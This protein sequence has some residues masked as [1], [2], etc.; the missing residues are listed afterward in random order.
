MCPKTNDGNNRL[1]CFLC[2]YDLCA[3]CCVVAEKQELK[4]GYN[5]IFRKMDANNDGFVDLDEIKA[6]W[7]GDSLARPMTSAM[8]AMEQLWGMD[9]NHDGKVSKSEWLSFM[10]G[11][12]TDEQYQENVEIGKSALALKNLGMALC[13][14]GH[15]LR[16]VP[17]SGKWR[18][19]VCQVKS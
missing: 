9:T 4:E 17:A 10:R 15:P 12:I 19:N 8:A 11:K 2:D 7:K 5:K 16:L 6:Y 13:L 1:N 14:Q 18:C 3:E